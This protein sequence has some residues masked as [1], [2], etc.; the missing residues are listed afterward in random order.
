M[1]FPLN[2]FSSFVTLIIFFLIVY[3]LINISLQC[4]LDTHIPAL[5]FDFQAWTKE[6]F[7]YFCDLHFLKIVILLGIRETR[8]MDTHHTQTPCC[9]I[10][11]LNMENGSSDINQFVEKAMFCKLGCD[12]MPKTERHCTSI[13][14]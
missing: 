9:Y 4:C 12:C 2:F 10:L 5:N 11:K 1:C 14:C 8:S 13:Y 6:K 7:K 3:L